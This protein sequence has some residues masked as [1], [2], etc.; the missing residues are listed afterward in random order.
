MY[1]QEQLQPQWHTSESM[2]YVLLWCIGEL[3]IFISERRCTY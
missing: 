3:H 1:L 2:K